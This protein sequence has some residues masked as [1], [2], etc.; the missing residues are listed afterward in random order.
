MNASDNTTCKKIP[1][2]CFGVGSLFGEKGGKL[3]SCINNNDTPKL[4]NFIFFPDES[5]PE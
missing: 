2:R 5:P 4:L 1:F 3:E